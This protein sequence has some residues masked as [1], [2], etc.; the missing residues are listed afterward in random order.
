M[1]IYIRYIPSYHFYFTSFCCDVTPA[2]VTVALPGTR[3]CFLIYWLLIEVK[4]SHVLF[5]GIVCFIVL[6]LWGCMRHFCLVTVLPAV[7]N[8]QLPLCSISARAANS[9]MLHIT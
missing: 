2:F 5:K 8:G 1:Y 7:D 4:T 9:N 6:F 3:Q